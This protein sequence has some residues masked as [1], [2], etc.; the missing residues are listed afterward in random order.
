M[1]S[2]EHFLALAATPH[3]KCTQGERCWDYDYGEGRDFDGRCGYHHA[4]R[5][6]GLDRVLHAYILGLEVF[7]SIGDSRDL[8]AWAT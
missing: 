1:M 2:Q 8:K 7:D 6:I 5:C 4:L 3:L